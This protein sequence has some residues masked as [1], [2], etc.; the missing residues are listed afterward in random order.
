[1]LKKVLK[2]KTVN[3]IKLEISKVGRGLKMEDARIK[4]EIIQNTDTKLFESIEF[5]VIKKKV[6]GEILVHIPND[7]LFEPR[8]IKFL[9]LGLEESVNIV[10]ELQKFIDDNEEFILKAEEELK[11]G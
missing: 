1:M 3:G 10:R 2:E 7:Y 6:G 11:N 5:G 8:K 4:I 9:S